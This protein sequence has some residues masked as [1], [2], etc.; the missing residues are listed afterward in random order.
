MIAGLLIGICVILPGVS[1]GVIA[2]ILGIYDKIIFAIN[3][4]KDNKKGNFIFLFKIFIGLVLGIIISSKILIYFFDKYHTEMSY[5]FIGLILGSIPLLIKNYYEK[6]NIKLNYP[7][8]LSISIISIILSIVIKKDIVISGDENN[9]LLLFISGFIFAIG[10]VIPGVSSSV[11]L[12]LIGR[13]KLYLTI[14]SNP[15]SYLYN[16]LLNL[17]IIIIGFVIGLLL[18]LKLMSF[19]LKKY[20]S[21]TYSIII[22]FVIG[23]VMIMY[24]Y[25]ITFPGILIM[26]IGFIFSLGIPLMKK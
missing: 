12:N 26:I 24:P 25:E 16:N 3:N 13:Y 14:F 21:I 7:I 22:G 6:T 1:G 9:V 4:F 23:S 2:V 20:Y 19:L 10:K 8:L 11:L 18:S 17:I 15:I 5:L